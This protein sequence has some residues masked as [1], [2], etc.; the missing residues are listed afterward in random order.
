MSCLNERFVLFVEHDQPQV[1]RRREHGAARAD[2]H[3]HL[4]ARNP[5]PVPMP[6]GIAQ[7]AVQHGHVAEP[8]AKPFPRLRRQADLRHQ[9]D[10]LPAVA[11]HFFDRLDVD[12]RLAA[13]GD[14]VNQN[15][16]VPRRPQRLRIALER[17]LLI[18]VQLQI[19]SAASAPRAATRPRSA[20]V[21]RQQ[22]SLSCAAPDR[23]QRAFGG[24]APTR[25]AHGSSA[26]WPD[27]ATISTCF[28]D[29]F[30]LRQLLPSL[31]RQRQQRDPACPPA[32]TPAGNTASST[33]PSG[34]R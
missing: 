12:F 21:V 15:R 22:N 30:E 11:D 6:L 27:T 28:F 8:R 25:A 31:R 2:D 24:R 26:G 19:R 23:P 7:M 4:A 33:C 10:R 17:R 14:A 29:S 32:R 13:A 20:A 1:R 9:H 18:G 3:L 5:L 16:L 34:H